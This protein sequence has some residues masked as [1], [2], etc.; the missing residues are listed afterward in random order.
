MILCS[1]AAGT[2]SILLV[3]AA[4]QLNRPRN[5][6]PIRWPTL[7]SCEIDKA[8][9]LSICACCELLIASLIAVH[10]AAV[11]L[12]SPRQDEAAF[13]IMLV[14][15]ISFLVLEISFL[16]LL[17]KASRN[18]SAQDKETRRLFR[19]RIA[20]PLSLVA[21]FAIEIAVGGIHGYVSFFLATSAF[22]FFLWITHRIL[23]LFRSS[24]SDSRIDAPPWFEPI[25]AAAFA[26]L[27][28][29]YYFLIHVGSN[30]SAR[31]M[32]IVT[33]I[34]DSVGYAMHAVAI[35]G[36]AKLAYEAFR[37][38]QD[39]RVRLKANPRTVLG[40]AT[41]PAPPCTPPH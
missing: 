37:L 14:L 2:T 13:L 25:S 32:E 36:L 11:H 40:L 12:I 1:Y 16:I 24:L 41:T 23:I 18:Q 5:E 39:M 33:G 17:W 9:D 30:F 31:P 10:V 19:L 6:A 7:M 35:F 27:Y 38:Q 22:V 34:K 8:R 28:L 3:L 29:L 20:I 21:V 15:L 26:G 4:R